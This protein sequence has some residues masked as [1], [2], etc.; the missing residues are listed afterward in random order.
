MFAALLALATEGVFVV[1]QGRIR[2]CNDFL[3]TRAGYRRAEVLETLFASF[4]DP[5]SAAAVE[6]LCRGRAVRL[7]AAAAP[8]EVRLVEKNGRRLRGTLRA[9][10]CRF[11]GRPAVL[12]VFSAAETP[13]GPT[14][15]EALPEAGWFPEEAAAETA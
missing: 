15:W 9:R 12:V 11:G 4:F 10:R 1:Q 7:S 5:D 6:S 3:E 2:E 8:L 13:P 14:I